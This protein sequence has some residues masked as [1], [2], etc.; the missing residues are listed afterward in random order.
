M[1]GGGL[2][3]RSVQGL[4]REHRAQRGRR[5]GARLLRPREECLG[6]VSCSGKARARHQVLSSWRRD[7]ESRQGVSCTVSVRRQKASRRWMSAAEV[8]DVP[9]VGETSTTSCL[10]SGGVLQKK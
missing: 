3:V 2:G 1:G 9:V 8:F 5:A 4:R 6:P 7:S 10:F